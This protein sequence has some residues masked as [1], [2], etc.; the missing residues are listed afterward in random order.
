MPF[1]DFFADPTENGLNR[2]NNP[3]GVA[4]ALLLSLAALLMLPAAGAQ[5]DL[6]RDT[7]GR[8][9]IRTD[10]ADCFAS[11][12]NITG[13]TCAVMYAQIDA[14]LLIGSANLQM[15][16]P[17]CPDVA[18]GW[19]APNVPGAFDLARLDLLIQG[20][21]WVYPDGS[22]PC[23]GGTWPSLGRAD[24]LVFAPG[25]SILVHWF[26]SAD[27]DEVRA[28]QLDAS[29]A[30]AGALPCLRVIAELV[31]SAPRPD[32]EVPPLLSGSSTRTVL[33]GNANEILAADDPCADGESA[34]R[35]PALEVAPVHEFVID[36]GA[37][38]FNV[39]AEQ[40]LTLRVRWTQ[41]DPPG[42]SSGF[43]QREWNVHSG[44]ALRPRVV[45]PLREPF[46][47]ADLR[48]G[49]IA[50]GVRVN[51]TLL[52]PWGFFDADHGSISLAVRSLGGD[53]LALSSWPV[54]VE[55]FTRE[56]S[57]PQMPTAF[58]FVIPPGKLPLGTYEATVSGQNWQHTAN[59]TA[60]VVFE[61]DGVWDAAVDDQVPALGWAAAA[62]VFA[63][64]A[65]V[66]RRA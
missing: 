39:S 6:Y 8:P 64:A 35:S 18:R 55:D 60:S 62:L 21:F 17:D 57:A 9:E 2:G 40:P 58:R 14:S 34:V 49:E 51:G 66:R 13:A 50:D 20:A 38:A 36:L 47:V 5:S 63:L 32:E 65:A 1:F 7:P 52:S 28:A 22:D 19:T 45:L 16:H 15:P 46:R 24:E 4:R 61:V 23:S 3:S 43:T 25:A 42:A 12:A 54:V 10:G 33:T 53:G 41:V 31:A 29:A 44:A 56:H 11:V 30:D 27:T 59:A 48:A 37:P 26:M